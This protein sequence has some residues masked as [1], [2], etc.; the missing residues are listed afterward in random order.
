MQSIHYYSFLFIRLLRPLP[1]RGIE[2][3]HALPC[4]PTW[5]CWRRRPPAPWAPPLK[6]RRRSSLWRRGRWSSAYDG[7][8]FS[9]S[10]RFF[11]KLWEARSR[12][13]RNE[14]LQVNSRWK[15]LDEIYKI[16]KPLHR[17]EL[18]N[19]AKFRQTFS[20]FYSF[21]FEISLIFRNCCPNLTNFDEVFP[22]I[23]EIWWKR[24][25]SPRFSNFLRFRTENCW[26]F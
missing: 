22:E 23:Q 5:I 20:H 8:N 9:N 4:P 24:S 10:W 6:R 25:K 17:S 26:I 1:R 7:S 12:L 3:S 11:G 14:S 16:H 2:A 18:K 15:A 13:Y 21:V 19:S